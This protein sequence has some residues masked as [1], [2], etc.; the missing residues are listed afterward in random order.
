MPLTPE[1]VEHVAL[2]GRLELEEKERELFT[3]QLSAILD[4]FEQLKQLNTS[5][6]PPTS[7][8]IPLQN[9]FREDEPVPSLSQEETL[10]NAPQQKQGCFQVP[11]IIE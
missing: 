4:Y 10:A 11:R 3:K 6:V 7:H 8:V 5:G 9:V 1:E 2:L